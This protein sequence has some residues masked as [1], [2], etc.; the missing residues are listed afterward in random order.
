MANSTEFANS[1]IQFT[2][3]AGILAHHAAWEG[4]GKDDRNNIFGLYTLDDLRE[5]GYSHR[6]LL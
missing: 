3:L 5:L 6:F 1:V 2:V 4:R